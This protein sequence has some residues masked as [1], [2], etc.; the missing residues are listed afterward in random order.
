MARAFAPERVAVFR[1]WKNY[2]VP[3]FLPSFSLRCLRL[4][5]FFYNI[6]TFFFN[7][8]DT[9]RLKD[10]LLDL[11]SRP[12]NFAISFSNKIAFYRYRSDLR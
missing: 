9:R 12:N 7:D 3:Q 2:I 6:F 5:F 11:E 10:R 1:N 4:S 8:R